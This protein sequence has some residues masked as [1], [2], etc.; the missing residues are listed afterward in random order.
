MFKPNLYHGKTLWNRFEGWYFKIVN[1]EATESF[2]FIPGVF[3]GNS[4]EESH[5]FLQ[6][7][8]GNSV[9]YNY[10]RFLWDN[11]NAT[12][13]PFSVEINDNTFS[14]EGI[15]LSIVTSQQNMRGSLNFSNLL[16][17]QDKIY[18]PGSM[19]PFN[20]I[21]F[22]QCYS[23]VC[24]MDM[25]ISGQLTINGTVHNFNNGKGY[26]E[27]NWGNSFPISWIWIQSNN[28]S[29]PK[30]SLSCS[31][32]HIP[33]W[34]TDFRGFLVGFYASGVFYQFTTMNG[35]TI[36]I[37][38]K[39]NNVKINLINKTHTLKIQT[40][41]DSDSFIL[42]K[43]PRNGKM[44]PLVNECLTGKV[45]VQL[46]ENRSNK[47]ILEDIGFATGIEYGGELMK[48]LDI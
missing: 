29:H 35:S 2:A 26:I 40:E 48:I 15:N 47:I 13:S 22:M 6:V 38:E 32:G 37:E 33:F 25:D 30:T 17:W 19:G 41:S 18:S 21:P 28:F 42:C 31:I 24:V 27:K 10:H 7:L 4:K 43:G 20:F 45:H 3:W 46:F 8:E 5:S 36:K 9:K 1:K 14:L 44:I 16:N 34:F 11:F 39:N 23:Q 12:H